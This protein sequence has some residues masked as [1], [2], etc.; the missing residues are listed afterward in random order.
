MPIF[1]KAQLDA[2]IIALGSSVM[3]ANADCTSAFLRLNTR[4]QTLNATAGSVVAAGIVSS[5]QIGASDL[6]VNFL[7]SIGQ[8]AS[9]QFD[10]VL[11]TGFTFTSI[12][13]GAAAT[14]AGKSVQ[15]S[16]TG[17][18]LRTLVFGVNQTTIGQGLLLT[19]RFT[20]DATAPKRL[21]SL[22]MTGLTGSTPAGLATILSGVSGSVTLT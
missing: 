22:A 17:G 21:Y 14:A 5:P 6:P 7:P 4:L 2:T 9:L 8:I 3:S 1:T 16:I 11:P 15:A 10:L 18:V 20:T 13:I 19:L 12:T